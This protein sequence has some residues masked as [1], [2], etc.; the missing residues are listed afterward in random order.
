MPNVKDV[1]QIKE[2]FPTLVANKV[3]KMIRAK[4]GSKRQK[5]PRITITTKGP[6]RKQII[7]PIAKSNTELIINSANQQI[8]NINK[9]LKE[10][11]SD[12]TVDFICIIN[13]GIMITTDKLMNTLDLKITEK[14]IKNINEIKS[15]SIKSPCLSKSKSYLKIVE[16]PYI[17][18]HNPITPDIIESIFKDLHIF[19]NIMLASKLCIIKVSPK[20]DIAVV[21]VDIWDLQSESTAKNIINQQFNVRQY[22]AT[23]YSMMS[24]ISFS[25]YLYNQ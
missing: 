15:D 3:V 9:S 8:A 4:N 13:N 1:L 17:L 24:Q 5:K 11:K 19:N 7:N 21:W 20:S 14:C 22:I 16:L 6:L 25:L 10:I 2:V 23:I 12:I 18:E